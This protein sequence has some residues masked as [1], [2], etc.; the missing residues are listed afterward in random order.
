MISIA[1]AC[2]N[3]ENFIYEQIQS[4]LN[5]T[6]I[7][8]EVIVCDDKSTDN[9]VKIIQNIGD[10]RIKL[11]QNV[12]QLGVVKNFEKAIS[13]CNGEYIALSDQDD[14]WVE[15]KLEKQL[16]QYI[17]EREKYPSGPLLLY[18]DLILVDKELKVLEDSFWKLYKISNFSLAKNL[19]DNHVTGCTTFF[20]K[21]TCEYY[22]PFISS[23]IL[24]DHSMAILTNC[25]GKNIEMNER[26]IKFRRHDTNSTST[27]KEKN[28]LKRLTYTNQYEKEIK[29]AIKFYSENKQ[30]LNETQQKTFDKFIRLEN[31]NK[32]YIMLIKKLIF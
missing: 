3:G 25:F 15:K 26:L 1:L 22:L 12:D 2:Y 8:L 4:I 32:F 31:K 28:F 10:N 19:F 11:F 21:I 18:H 24:H 23:E 14:I 13:L 17:I 29:F 27:N 16:H 6:M 5:Q 9:T 30:R 20:D 7:D